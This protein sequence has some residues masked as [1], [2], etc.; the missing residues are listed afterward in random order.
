[1]IDLILVFFLG[2]FIPLHD[3]FINITEGKNDVILKEPVNSINTGAAIYIDVSNLVREYKITPINI[4]EVITNKIDKKCLSVSLYTK[5]GK[6]QIFI[7]NG[8]TA[9]EPKRVFLIATSDNRLNNDDYFVRGVVNSCRKIDSVA[10]YWK[11]HQ[12]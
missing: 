9:Y 2:K 5:Q 4:N 6:Q 3:G 12:L 11:N 1:M 7:Y 8:A 10:F